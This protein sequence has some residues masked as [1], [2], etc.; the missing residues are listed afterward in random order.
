[1]TQENGLTGRDSNAERA[2][3]MINIEVMQELHELSLLYE[4]RWGKDVD[5]VG[6]PTT[7]S[8]KRLLLILRY[9][10]DTGDSVLVGAQKVRDILNEYH[11]YIE[12]ETAAHNWD[13]ENG[14]VFTKP[15]P[16]CGN[17]VRYKIHGNS[18]AYECDTPHCFASVVRGI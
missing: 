6:M 1:M 2:S 9:I 4:A 12:K 17:K 8:E 7:I 3:T 18:Y 5:Y 11:D 13:V 10:V 16:L 14:Y 15:C